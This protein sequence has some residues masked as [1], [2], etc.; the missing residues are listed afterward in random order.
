MA[1]KQTLL[2]AEAQI[3]QNWKAQLWDLELKV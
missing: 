3:Y 2:I 1:L